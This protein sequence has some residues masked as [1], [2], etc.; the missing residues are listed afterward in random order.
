VIAAVYSSWREAAPTRHLKSGIKPP[1]PVLPRVPPTV[2]AGGLDGS[3]RVPSRPR[4][5]P[6][7]KKPYTQGIRLDRTGLTH[8]RRQARL[9]LRG[10]H[11]APRGSTIKI[12]EFA[13]LYVVECRGFLVGPSRPDR[14][15]WQQCGPINSKFPNVNSHFQHPPKVPNSNSP[16]F[17]PASTAQGPK[18]YLVEPPCTLPLTVS[19]GPCRC[20]KGDQVAASFRVQAKATCH[21]RERISAERT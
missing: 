20:T 6:E 15:M 14:P 18:F 4:P 7:S 12:P 16:A 21:C 11:I 5:A 13:F 3:L 2:P 1:T 17:F 19:L 8:R 10:P 9:R